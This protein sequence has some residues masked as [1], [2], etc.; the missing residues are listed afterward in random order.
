MIYFPPN[1][2]FGREF[3]ELMLYCD[4]FTLSSYLI[5]INISLWVN[6]LLHYIL[7]ISALKTRLGPITFCDH[8]C[9]GC[10]LSYQIKCLPLI[11]KASVISAHSFSL[12][13]VSTQ[14]HCDLPLSGSLHSK[15]PPC[16]CLI[17]PCVIYSLIPRGGIFVL[18]SVLHQCCPAL[19]TVSSDISG[20]FYAVN[21][22]FISTVLVQNGSR[23][24]EQSLTHLFVSP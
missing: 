18:K 16:L 17:G 15:R 24:S 2:P 1:G 21:H 7:N 3:W 23:R 19:L 12:S 22:W 6:T 11:S 4:Y 14:V 10:G 20:A 8:K 5:S 13:R 9:R